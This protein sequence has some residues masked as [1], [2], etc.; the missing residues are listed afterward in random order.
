MDRLASF[1]PGRTYFQGQTPSAT[2]GA[3]LEGRMHEGK[4]YDPAD[5][6]A[7]AAEGGIRQ[8]MIVRNAST[9][10]LQKKQVVKWKS[11]QRNR[12]VDGYCNVTNEEVAG[13]VDPNLISAGVPINDLFFLV[14]DGELLITTPDTGAGFGGDWSEGDKLGALTNAASTGPDAGRLTKLDGTATNLT[15]DAE[16]NMCARV[17]SGKTTGQ[18]GEDCLVDFKLR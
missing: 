7:L 11:G 16:W 1:V 18:T 15:A 3:H 17:M 12:Q 8:Y 5:P 13:V 2:D 9:I 6:M 4:P 10:V 14:V